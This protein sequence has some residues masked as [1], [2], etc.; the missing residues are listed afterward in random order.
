[1]EPHLQ[2]AEIVERP[3]EFHGNG[4]DDSTECI[5]SHGMVP[6][7]ATQRPKHHEELPPA[8][9]GRIPKSLTPKPW[10]AHTLRTK[11]GHE[12][13]S[14]LLKKVAW[15]PRSSENQLESDGRGVHP[16]VV[17]QAVRG[18]RARTAYF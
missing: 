11:T 4:G 15:T 9:C 14:S 1:M 13:L 18:P 7:R 2:A 10:M 8:P 6:Y 16:T 12:P 3:E 17:Q 5:V